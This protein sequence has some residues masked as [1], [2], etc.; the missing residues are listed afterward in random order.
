MK[1][2]VKLWVGSS[3]PGAGAGAVAGTGAGVIGGW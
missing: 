2:R 1:V 3:L